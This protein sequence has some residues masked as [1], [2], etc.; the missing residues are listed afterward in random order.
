MILLDGEVSVMISMLEAPGCP[1][2]LAYPLITEPVILK[3]FY[4][5]WL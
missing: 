3:V 2:P 1:N 5:S 4:C